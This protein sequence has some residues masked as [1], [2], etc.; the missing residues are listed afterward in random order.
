VGLRTRLSDRATLLR[1]LPFA[2][3]MLVLALRDLLPEGWAPGGIDPGWLYAVQAGVAGLLIAW[4][5]RELTE[6]ASRPCL[7]DL[8]LA[9]VVG[10]AVYWIWIRLDEPWMRLGSPTHAFDP[11]GSDGEVMWGLIAVRWL[12]AA[13]VVPLIEE[14]FWRSF[15][16][17]WI[18]RP[19]F[20]S[21]DPKRIGLKAVLLSSLV[22]TLAHTEWLAAALAGLAYAWLY[23][24]TGTLWAPVIAHVV[25]NAL[26]GGWVVLMGA[27]ALW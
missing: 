13:L 16:M 17:R 9:V 20:L 19:D 25:T 21:V 6:L 14:L 26:L 1:V 12:G 2:A 8:M 23:V 4:W 24:R 5:W 22:F 11:V 27:W 7:R 18:E 15:L 10:V 3:F